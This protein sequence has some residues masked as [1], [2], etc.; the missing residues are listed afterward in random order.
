MDLSNLSGCNLIGFTSSLSLLISENLSS[1]E[2]GLLA[3][4]I[5]SLGDN[6]ALLALSK[7]IEESNN[8]NKKG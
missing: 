8:K 6:L 2:I 3:A 5:V 7:A 4:F 1:E